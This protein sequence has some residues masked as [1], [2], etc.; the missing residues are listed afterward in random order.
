MAVAGAG[1]GEGREGSCS[2]RV[3]CQSRRM[4][5]VVLGSLLHNRVCVAKNIVL[6]IWKLLE[7]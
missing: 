3:E 7:E 4:S 5:G 6:Y 1:G 2:Q